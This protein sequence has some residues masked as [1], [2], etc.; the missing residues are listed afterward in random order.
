MTVLVTG[1]S[2]FIGRNLLMSLA[3]AGHKTVGV[4]R[5][6][7]LNQPCHDFISI[8]QVDVLDGATD[9][10]GL[11]GNVSSVVH[12]AA[13]AHGKPGDTST[14]NTEATLNLARQA[15]S[16]GV[17]RFVFLSSIGVHGSVN[18][19]PYTEGDPV[20][21]E[22]DYAQSKWLAEQGLWSIQEESG[23]ELVVIRPPLVYGPGAPGNFASLVHWVQKGIPLPLG[24]IN[25][26]RSLVALDNL[27]DLIVTCIGHPAASNQTF[28]VS[29]GEDI[30]TTELLL[31]VAEASGKSSRL[32]PVPAS[33]LQFGATLFGKKAVAQRLLGSLQVDISHTRK[34]L[35]W[36][37][38]LTVKQGLQ[39]CFPNQQD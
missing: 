37:P 23:M 21:P 36:T 16:A 18:S 20:N 31:G 34:C 29:D 19:V 25:N 12:C 27:L 6:G 8:K 3:D 9:W 1:A 28:L 2:G 4:V 24:A 13:V 38:P 39:R 35:N 26:K 15:V 11:F 10:S 22:N 5:S 7:S 32:I 14:I 33:W 17:R 30:S